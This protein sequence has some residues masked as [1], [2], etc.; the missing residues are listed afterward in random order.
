M[1]LTNLRNTKLYGFGAKKQEETNTLLQ[2]SSPVA[3]TR[4]AAQKLFAPSR[5]VPEAKGLIQIR[6]ERVTIA[7]SRDPDIV[8]IPLGSWKAESLFVTAIELSNQSLQVRELDPEQF[9]GDWMTATFHHARLLPN[10]AKGDQSIVYL[11]SSKPFHEALE[12]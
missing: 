5:L 1:H 10:G 8:A 3:L 11:V 2:A 7:L 12:F 9:R 6:I 4:F